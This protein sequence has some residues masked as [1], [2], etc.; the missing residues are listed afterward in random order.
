MSALDDF[1][2]ID[3][4]EEAIK[5]AIDE[6]VKDGVPYN[7]NFSG[8]FRFSTD[9]LAQTQF[10]ES[11][12]LARDYQSVEPP[13]ALHFSHGQYIGEQGIPNLIEQLKVK[14]NSNRAII[15]LISQQDIFNSEDSPIPSFMVIQCA[16]EDRM[17][18]IT[19]Y[20]R[21]LEVS[22]FLKVNLEEIRMIALEVYKELLSFNEVAL[23]LIAF[24]AYH[25]PG[26]NVLLKCKLDQLDA[27]KILLL[28]Q[29]NPQS[30]PDLLKEKATHSTVISTDSLLILKRIITDDE[31]RAGL[32]FEIDAMRMKDLLDAA[33][34]AG[35]ALSAIRAKASHHPEIATKTQEFNG[36]ITQ[37]AE[38][39]K[40]CL[41]H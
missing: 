9:L 30:I 24:R 17:L 3:A 28:L 25:Q 40:L 41:E 7:L 39:F 16:I 19:T 1:V 2:K 35:E 13:K 36:F 22:E 18:F 33:I 26:M 29:T 37:A 6:V 38:A 21:A 8:K 14:Q 5:I 12:A 20:F 31:V 27:V 32:P 10:P 23:N 15:S 4:F 11:E 34:A